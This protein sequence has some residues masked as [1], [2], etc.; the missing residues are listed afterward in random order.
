MAKEVT[1][2]QLFESGVYFGHLTRFR[3]PEMEEYIYG[4]NNKINIIDLEKTLPMF[5]K[6]MKFIGQV[7]GRGGKVLFVGTKR[8][9]RDL[10][11]EYAQKCGMPYVNH[12]C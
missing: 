3:E 2:R 10:V 4:T 5:R 6:A 7:I 11:A 9:A 12:R 8:T 1:M